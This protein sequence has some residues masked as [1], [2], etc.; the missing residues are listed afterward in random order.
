MRPL[1]RW[2]RFSGHQRRL[3]VIGENIDVVAFGRGHL[4]LLLHLFHGGD[5]IAQRGRLFEARFFGRLLHPRA[6]IL[7]QIVVPAFQEQ[8]HVANRRGVCF[9]GGQ[10][11]THGPRQRWM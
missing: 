6:Q 11:F 4:L 5:Q 1:R 8:P 10:P 2:N 7:G 9:V 3:G